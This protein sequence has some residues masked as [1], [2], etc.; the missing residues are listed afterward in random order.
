M[1][2]NGDSEV[3]EERNDDKQRTDSGSSSSSSSSDY[4]DCLHTVVQQEQ[5]RG[6]ECASEEDRKLVHE[7]ACTD[8]DVDKLLEDFVDVSAADLDC[9]EKS[10][11]KSIMSSLRSFIPTKSKGILHHMEFHLKNDSRSRMGLTIIP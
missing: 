7:P 9:N 6:L 10:Q 5:L 3:T 4:A 1:A 8:I 2:A 11:K